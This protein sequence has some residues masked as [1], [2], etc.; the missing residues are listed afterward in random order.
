MAICRALKASTRL[1]K[2]NFRQNDIGACGGKEIG[3]MLV[4][5][6]FRLRKLNVSWNSIK[7]QGSAAIC[8]GLSRNK[9]LEHLDASWNCFSDAAALELGNALACNQS[10]QRAN[11]EH[12]GVNDVAAVSHATLSRCTRSPCH[13]F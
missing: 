7:G 10:L 9:F 3:E 4:S 8:R 2:L 13:S 1:L 12:C 5:T 6:D 11:L